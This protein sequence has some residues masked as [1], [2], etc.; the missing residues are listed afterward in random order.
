ML[1]PLEHTGVVI[2]SLN[3]IAIWFDIVKS[4]IFHWDS[5]TNCL[6]LH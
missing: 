1:D 2:H 5:K 6:L 4:Q 3:E